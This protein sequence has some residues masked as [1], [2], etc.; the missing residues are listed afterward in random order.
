MTV[1]VGKVPK[2]ESELWGYLSSGDGMRCPVYSRCQNRLRGDWCPSDN[3][4]HITHL[5][6]DRRFNIS[7]YTSII[8]GIAGG[9]CGRVFQLV[10]RMAFAL[11]S[12]TP[13]VRRYL[14]D[15]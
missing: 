11:T 4:N 8:G 13:T 15:L 7:K 3:I 6:D 14:R 5:L 2:W 9:E 10:E 1:G 12:T